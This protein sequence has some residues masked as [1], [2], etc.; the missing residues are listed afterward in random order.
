MSNNKASGTVQGTRTDYDAAP[1]RAQ[2][3][4]FERRVNGKPLHYL[5]NAAT[6]QMPRAVLDAVAEHET[7]HRANV[8]RSI[9]LL[10]E[11][12]TEAFEDAR[13]GVAGF[14]NATDPN[15][16]VFT[17]GTTSA[18]NLVAYA[19]GG[20]LE[21]GDEV[22]ISQVEHHSNIVPWQMLRDRQGVELKVLPATPEG[23]VDLGA[24]SQMVTPKTRLVSVIH[25]SNVSGAITP[26]APVVDAARA[27][28]AKVLLDGAQMAPHG[29]V[30]VQALGVDFYAFSSHKAYGP[31]GAGVLWG[32]AEALA[33]LPPF[34]SGGEMI[35][36][37]TLEKTDYAD[38]PHRFEAGTPPIAQ[39]VGMGAAL[40][41][42]SEQDLAGA[43][44]HLERLTGRVLDGLD[45]IDNGR[46]VMRLIGSRELDRRLPAISF[47]VDGLH[48]H[49]ICQVLDGHGVALRGGHH[50]AQPLMDFFGLA[51]TTRAS[52]ALYNDDGDVDAFLNGLDDAIKLLKP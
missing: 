26:A 14:V 13:A 30:D 18:I 31:N 38:P 10:A 48:P 12:A 20:A 35:R 7:R 28:G 43:A 19:L 45:A 39:A 49:D 17:S 11:E 6:G 36:T 44:R 3:P 46:G 33:Q 23:A 22:V 34:M 1:V 5:D 47:A 42:L 41:W 2:F 16:V 9:H 32:R 24:L 27:V 37:V 40:K 15:E 51:G 4:I 52:L 25:G 50:C 29:P 8:L 21:P